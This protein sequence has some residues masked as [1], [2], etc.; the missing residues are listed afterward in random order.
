MAHGYLH[1]PR[2]FLGLPKEI[3]LIL[4][5]FFKD[6]LRFTKESLGFMKDF[7]ELPQRFLEDIL[8]DFGRFA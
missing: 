3:S 4:I 1:D 5:G 7:F 8:E 6:S 2:V